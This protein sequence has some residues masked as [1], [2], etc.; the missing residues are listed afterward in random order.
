LRAI[1]TGE[2][3]NVEGRRLLRRVDDVQRR[4]TW[5]ALPVAVAKKFGDDRAGRLA[6]VVAYH[7]FFS[8]FPL[9]LVF[10]SVVGFVLQGNPDLQVRLVDS[11]LAT[12]PVVGAEIGQT[13][14]GTTGSSVGVAL[15]LGLALWA[16][17][18][19]VAAAQDAVNDVWNVSLQARPGLVQRIIRGVLML[20]S[21][22][23]ALAVSAALVAVGS[24]GGWLS[25]AMKAF[26]LAGSL[27][28]NVALFLA[29]YAVLT[30]VT[31]PTRSHLPGAITAGAA[32][33][34]LLSI[35]S[36]FVDRQISGA[37]EVYGVFALVLGLL[38]WIHLGAQILLVGAEVS[39]V[40]ARR[41]WP[42]SLIESSD[43]PTPSA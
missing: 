11:A 3:A 5:T 25:P 12:L 20:V 13:V 9:L 10:V 24:S 32:W 31:V 40:R 30:A 34:V 35:G 21:F 26:S 43:G 14:Q 27:A 4:R 36:W 33:T 39:V 38:V 1:P 17:L 16:G 6:A 8:V 29:V 22:G 42:R 15:G 28:L 7:G 2:R 18:G 41:L 37:S 23:V 19:V